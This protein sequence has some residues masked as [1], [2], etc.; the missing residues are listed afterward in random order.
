MSFIFNEDP[1]HVSKNLDLCSLHFT[2]DLFTNKAQFNVGFSE[3]LK[4]KDNAV[5]WMTILDLTVISHRRVS[6]C[7]HYMVTIAWYVITDRL[8]CTEYLCVLT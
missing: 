1:D 5:Y 7:F 3:R 8:I 4:L 2:T 6:N